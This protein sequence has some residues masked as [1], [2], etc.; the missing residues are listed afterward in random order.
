VPCEGECP[1][2]RSLVLN[3][4][5][6][7]RNP[8]RPDLPKW[9]DI[10]ALTAFDQLHAEGYLESSVGSGTYVARSIPDQAGKLTSVDAPWTSSASQHGS[11]SR[12]PFENLLRGLKRGERDIFGTQIY[13]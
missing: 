1:P 11:R 5:P 9:L 10:T 8:G 7:D 4:L 2:E 12:R 6:V 3:Y 13:G